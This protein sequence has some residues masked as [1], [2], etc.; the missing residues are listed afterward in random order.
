MQRLVEPG[1]MLARVSSSFTRIASFSATSTVE[2]MSKES[3]FHKLKMPNNSHDRR[4]IQL[5]GLTKQ[6]CEHSDLHLKS[7]FA[8]TNSCTNKKLYFQ[9]SVLFKVPFVIDAS[10]FSLLFSSYLQFITG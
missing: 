6:Q 7:C 1:S 4:K 9:Q 8:Q 3:N 5:V 10:G 2:R